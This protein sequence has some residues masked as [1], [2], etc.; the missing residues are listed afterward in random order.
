MNI[1]I[2]TITITGFYES[3][4]NFLYIFIFIGLRYS[5]R[6]IFSCSGYTLSYKYLSFIEYNSNV[7]F[8]RFLLF[9][10]HK[11]IL[12]IIVSVFMRYALYYVNI[13]FHSNKNP[14]FELFK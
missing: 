9:Q 13:I 4:S 10:S 2:K 5:P 8:F 6:L 12:L 7:S 3:I 11:Y 1:L 14:I